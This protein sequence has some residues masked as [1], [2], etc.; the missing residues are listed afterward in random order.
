FIILP[1]ECQI[2]NVKECLQENSIHYSDSTITVSATVEE[3][4]FSLPRRA[5]GPAFRCTTKW[6]SQVAEK[7]SCMKTSIRARVY[8]CRKSF[9]MCWALAPAKCNWSQKRIFPQ[10]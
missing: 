6:A 5:V 10:P 8:S 3:H 4:A 7:V 1:A 9:R 2:K